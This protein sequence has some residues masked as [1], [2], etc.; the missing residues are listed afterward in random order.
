MVSLDALRHVERL[1]PSQPTVCGAGTR[2]LTVGPDGRVLLPC[3]HEWD[4][5]LT[6]DRPYRDLVEDPMFL[7][8]RD[9]EI[10][11]R[12]GCRSCSVFPYLGLAKSYRLT[13]DFL[14][15][16]V[17]HEIIKVKRCLEGLDGESPAPPTDLSPLLDRLLA[18]LDQL[19][20]RPGTHLDEL[21]RFDAVRGLGAVSDVAG[22][23]VAVEEVLAD[24]AREDC[25]GV[26]RTPHRIARLLYTDVVPALV[27]LARDGSS[28]A[29]QVACGT[30]RAHLALWDVWLDAFASHGST[31]PSSRGGDVLSSWCREA[32]NLLAASRRASAARSVAAIALASSVPEVDLVAWGGVNG[33]PEEALFAKL[34]RTVLPASRRTR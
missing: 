27:D 9:T 21:Y 13:A 4:S 19:T 6:W 33:H 29:R 26:Q 8:V 1:D 25:W 23:P 5:S 22:G 7:R 11:N 28:E 16:A 17:S 10:G 3:Y 34:A 14:M 32:G 18:R 15:Q 2:I 12:P 24:H 20:L 30:L 31:A